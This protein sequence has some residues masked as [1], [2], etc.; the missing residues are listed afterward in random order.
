MPEYSTFRKTTWD[1]VIILSQIATVQCFGYST[2]SFAMVVGSLFS[3][4]QLSPRLLFDSRMARSDTVEGWAVGLGLVLMGVAN[5]VPLVYM[6]ER[7]RLCIDFSV[8]FTAIHVILVWWHMGDPPTTLF[9]WLCVAVAG[10]VMAFGGR[11]ACLRREMLPIAIRSFMPNHPAERQQT[12]AGVE[13]H[14][15]ES[16]YPQNTHRD[17]PDI[18]PQT[19]RRDTASQGGEVLFDRAHAD[20]SSDESGGMISAEPMPIRRGVHDS[21]SK[22]T[23]NS[24]DD[25]DGWGVDSWDGD[26]DEDDKDDDN[27]NSTTSKPSGAQRLPLAATPTQGSAPPSR[28][29][30]PLTPRSKGAKD[31]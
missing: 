22:L 26:E 19:V 13:E 24:G 9:W 27:D 20:G 12:G 30:T 3:S 1:P 11:A 16:V 29:G 2:F 23:N 5:I 15:L 10:A 18:A 8:T 17:T 31:D 7:S 25:D 28:A 6:V 21:A 4:V 14:E